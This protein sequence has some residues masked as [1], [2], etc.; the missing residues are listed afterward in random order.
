VKYQI[1]HGAFSF[2][3]KGLY[4]TQP[5]ALKILK[6]KI[7]IKDKKA[8]LIIKREIKLLQ[9]F[10]HEN[11]TFFFGVFKTKKNIFEI[12]SI[13]EFLPI[14]LTILVL[15]YCDGG[16]LE[17]FIYS[18]K[19]FI[20]FKQKFKIL[21]DIVNG[22]VYL[23]SHDPPIIHRDLKPQNIL[24]VKSILSKKDIPQ[25][26]ITDFG[27]S[28]CFDENMTTRQGTQEYMAPEVMESKRY[29]SKCDVYSFGIILWQLFSGRLPYS[30][31]PGFNIY[32]VFQKNVRPNISELPSEVPD[33]IKVLMSKSWDPNPD[34][35][36][37]FQEIHEIIEAVTIE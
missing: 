15:E 29:D 36:P 35:R 34:M 33:Y 3:M 12:K 28:K 20:T 10:N 22:M 5:V 13:Q 30:D 21:R 26:K 6:K 25:V 2:V 32:S 4:K 37:S 31:L 23:H 8:S 17:N 24:L 11:I 14:K 18:T 7:G 16:S 27:I 1:G 9:S 19:S